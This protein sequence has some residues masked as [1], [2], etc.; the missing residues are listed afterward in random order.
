MRAASLIVATF[1]GSLLSA[2]D[3]DS[4]GANCPCPPQT[5]LET[6][7]DNASSTLGAENV[8][9]ALDELAARPVAGRMYVTDWQYIDATLA[10]V[11]I[12]VLCNDSM[13][14]IPLSVTCELAE[15]GTPDPSVIPFLQ[16]FGVQPWENGG[17]QAGGHC[18]WYTTDSRPWGGR[19]KIR[20]VCLDP[21]P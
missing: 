8:Q 7:F 17:A 2:C 14:D 16:A 15:G 11:S 13:N 18:D 3:G 5:A 9:D 20:L 21:T 12:G 10:G 4:Q 6:S 1:V 19:F